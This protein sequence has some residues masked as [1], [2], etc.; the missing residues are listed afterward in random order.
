M[1]YGTRVFRSMICNLEHVARLGLLHVDRSGENMSAASGTRTARTRLPERDD[2]AQHLIRL[3]AEL[4]E[5][6]HRVVC[7]ILG[8]VSVCGALG[9]A[10]V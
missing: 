8:Y 1:P 2:I 4:G 6:G 9:G 5:I 10:R 7:L 3:H